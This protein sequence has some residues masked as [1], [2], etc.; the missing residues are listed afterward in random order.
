MKIVP[1]NLKKVTN[2]SNKKISVVI[3][4]RMAASRFPG[5]PL[6][7]ILNLPMIEHVRRRVLLCE[8]ITSVYVATCDIE[9]KEVVES[10]GGNVIMTSS[11]HERCTDRIEE[12]SKK[13]DADIIVN[14]QGDEP[15]VLPQCVT[16][17]SLPLLKKDDLL[18]T[19]LIYEVKTYDELRNPNIVKAV[20]SKSKSIMYMGR[21]PIPSK[22][23]G[24]N[25][26]LYKQSGIMAFRK[27]FLIQFS[28]M[29]QTPLE[30]VESVDMMRV[31]END[32]KIQGIVTSYETPGVDIPNDIQKVEKLIQSD[33]LQSEIFRKILVI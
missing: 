13:I 2:L 16:D 17:V 28:S 31:L 20:L 14:I 23:I 33:T 27:N 25:P 30:R 26:T 5:K 22:R 11:K 15:C 1:I 3:P 29:S 19:C 24:E 10:Y 7:K 21:N 12:A 9:I 18:C 8:T 32:I 4:A 6:A